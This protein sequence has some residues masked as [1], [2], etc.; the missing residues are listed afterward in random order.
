MKIVHLEADALGGISTDNLGKYGDVVVYSNTTQNEIVNRCQGAEI[1][2]TNKVQITADI[3]NQ[4]PDLKLICEAA[5]G[6]NN[7]D[8]EYAEK[9]GVEVKNVANY[10]TSS[11]VQS[12]FALLL[13]L[14]NE[15]PYFDSYVKNGDYAQSNLF[16][17]YGRTFWQL[18]QKN[19]GIVGMGNIG[20]R[21]ALIAEA[22]GCRV[23][24]YSTSGANN[25]CLYERTSLENLLQKSDVV[26]I[27]APLN[28]KTRNLIGKEQLDL[29]KKSA[30]IINT[31]RG[32]IVNEA[33]L[34]AAIDEGIIRGAGLDVFSQEPI[35]PDNPL[36]HVKNKD[37][38]ILTPHVAWTSHEAR[39]LLVKKLEEN[40]SSFLEKYKG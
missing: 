28:E 17:N 4:L 5:T 38:L 8:V 33:D 10:S 25:D 19:F 29:M 16:T 13:S 24:Y 27:H 40:I 23:L 14:L 3:L 32:G 39:T 36:L 37:R 22:F 9:K 18:S 30:I 21:V 31:A 1:I 2:I 12:T 20:K 34:G 11:V 15:L 35:S 6:I 26:S 7:I